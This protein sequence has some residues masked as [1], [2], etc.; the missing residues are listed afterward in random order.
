MPTENPDRPGQLISSPL[1]HVAT[2]QQQKPMVK[3]IGRMMKMKHPGK[4]PKAPSKSHGPKK[5]LQANQSVAIKHKQI[6][7]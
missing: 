7:Y 4:T 6:F 2:A 3:L 1:V 5:G